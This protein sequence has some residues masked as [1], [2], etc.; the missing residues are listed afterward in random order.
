MRGA[1]GAV[2]DGC[3][4]DIEELR[5]AGLPVWARGLRLEIE[6]LQ[7]RLQQSKEQLLV[8]IQT[9]RNVPEDLV[10]AHRTQWV[11]E[12]MRQESEAPAKQ[13]GST[14]GGANTMKSRLRGA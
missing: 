7:A 9:V 3:V 13:R 12:R 4:T 11:L 5:Q 6:A 10:C 2:V 8:A 1:A 14:R